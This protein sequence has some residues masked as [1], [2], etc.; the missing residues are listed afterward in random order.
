MRLN[1]ILPLIAVLS[2]ALCASAQQS[3]L[4]PGPKPNPLDP[5]TM[6]PAKLLAFAQAHNG[7]GEMPGDGWHLK[8]TFEYNISKVGDDRFVN[9]SFDETWY[10]PQ[11]YRKTYEFKGVTH[12]DTATPNGLYRSGDQGWDTP[13]EV[14]VR[15]LLVSPVPQDPPSPDITLRVG[16]IPSGKATIPC[17]FEIYKMPAGLNKKDEKDLIDHSPRLCFDPSAPILRFSGGIGSHSEVTFSKIVKLN[18][19]LVAKEIIVMNGGVPLLRIHVEDASIP[20]DPTGPMTPTADAKKLVSPVTVA[21]ETIEPNRLPEPHAPVY[22]AG[23]IQEHLEGEVNIAVVIAPDGSVTSAKVVDGIQMLRDSAL[24]F[25]KQSRFKPFLLSGTPVEVHTTAHI[26]F[27][28]GMESA[29][30]TGGRKR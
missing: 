24:G 4:Q 10:A 20:P 8:G 6:P 14:A 15:N 13:E 25:V 22:P 5:S 23:A 27:G 19:H 21:W 11:N 16:S 12:T 1:T 30:P 17:L 9:G 28:A 18:N 29:E 26:Q 7:A 3:G 2:A